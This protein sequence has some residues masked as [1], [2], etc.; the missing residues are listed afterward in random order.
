VTI[1]FFDCR[2]PLAPAIDTPG[3]DTL[4]ARK[5][6]ATEVKPPYPTRAPH[7]EKSHKK[8]RSLSLP[9]GE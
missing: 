2:S 1:K 5:G 3:R 8:K 6:T 4:K 7:K 9:N